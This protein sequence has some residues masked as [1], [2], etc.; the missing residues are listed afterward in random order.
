[1]QNFNRSSF[2]TKKKNAL[3]RILQEESWII[4]VKTLRLLL[5]VYFRM[6]CPRLKAIDPPTHE[7]GLG[8]V[9]Q[10]NF[11]SCIL[12]LKHVNI[13]QF[14]HPEKKKKLNILHLTQYY[15]LL[16]QQLINAKLAQH[17]EVQLYTMYC[18]YHV[19]PQRLVN[20]LDRAV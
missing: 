2:R 17:I 12:H 15:P 10:H 16:L 19:L 18:M 3:C 8:V 7:M 14:M 11:K 4:E 1:M 9:Y 5:Q 6:R 13:V 20:A